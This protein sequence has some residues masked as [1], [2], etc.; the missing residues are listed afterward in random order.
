MNAYDLNTVRQ[1]PRQIRALHLPRAGLSQWPRELRECTNLRHLDLSGNQLTGFPHW[2]GHLSNLQ[3]LNL[4]DNQLRTAET[5][6]FHLRALRVLHLSQN[7]LSTLDGEWSLL[8]HLQRLHLDRNNLRKLPDNLGD[9]VSLTHLDVSKNPLQSCPRALF[10]LST[11]RSLNLEQTRLRQLPDE[12]Q[13][14]HHLETLQLGRNKLTDLPASLSQLPTLQYL[15][16]QRNQF[17][18][19]PESL[20]SFRFLRKLNIAHNKL[21]QLP[22]RTESLSWLG[23]VDLSQ[24]QLKTIPSTWGKN[25]R[26]EQLNLSGNMLT[27]LPDLSHLTYLRTLELMDNAL[28]ELPQLPV[29]LQK[30][31]VRRNPLLN[32]QKVQGATQLR[33]LDASYT[34]FSGPTGEWTTG[35]NLTTVIIFR[36]P[37]SK[38]ENLPKHMLQWTALKALKGYAHQ[39]KRGRLLHLLAQ[40]R[41]HQLPLDDR[42]RIWALLQGNTNHPGKLNP[43]W[44]LRCMQWSFPEL[45]PICR[46]TLI[47]QWGVTAHTAYL[48]EKGVW[49]LGQ[50]PLPRKQLDRE[51]SRHDIPVTPAGVLIFGKPPY[52][53]L[54]D[55][56]PRMDAIDAAD[57][58]HWLREVKPTA[59]NLSG[60]ERQTI[61]RLLFHQNPVNQ[62]L[63]LQLI[64]GRQLPSLVLPELVVQWKRTADAAI[65]KDIR[66]LLETYLAPHDR[67]I[68]RRRIAFSGELSP[69]AFR[70]KMLALTEESH[71]EVREI[72]E[73]IV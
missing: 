3:T 72:L 31:Q 30:L 52:V 66:H 35:N 49:C 42:Q 55:L 29:Q 33:Y 67:I 36:T 70:Q 45:W 44:C 6:L 56:Q 14:M 25:T 40:S 21:T 27:T 28:R 26:L 54:P 8:P 53:N 15:D 51:F 60:E 13:H 5:S 10:S 48:Q 50:M 19:F 32:L 24:N 57:V 63:A 22:T 37:L 7:K 58:L 62:R 38:R 69:A 17:T 20:L 34:A 64:A 23:Y 4:S 1:S 43:A 73:K 9:L 68:L 11:I 41:I 16:L 12:W 39:R 59:I 18:R 46:Q 61:R 2:L 65:R 71:I 47:D